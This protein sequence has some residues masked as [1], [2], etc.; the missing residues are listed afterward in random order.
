MATINV[1]DVFSSI[2]TAY[3]ID[4]NEDALFP[5]ADGWAGSTLPQVLPGGTETEVFEFG[6]NSYEVEISADQ[7]ISYETEDEVFGIAGSALSDS[8]TQNG[9]VNTLIYIWDPVES[10]DSQALIYVTQNDLPEAAV[11]AHMNGTASV[12]PLALAGDDLLYNEGY[13]GLIM[14]GM[15]GDDMI[16]GNFGSDTL[17]GGTGHDTLL[18]DEGSDRLKG[19]AGDDALLGDYG[20]DVLFGGAG[21]DELSGDEGRDRLFGGGGQD[22]LYGGGSIDV[23]KGGGGRDLLVGGDSNDRLFGGAGADTFVFNAFDGR[24][25]IKDFEIGFDTISL[26]DTAA[27]SFDDLAFRQRGDNAIVNY[28]DGRIVLVDTD[29]DELTATDFDFSFV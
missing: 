1:F 8:N 13:S 14:N 5:P 12:M 22:A 16:V 11:R 29:V 10:W 18:G 23:L 2:V 7:A 19:G 27:S 17:I 28:G 20:N 6:G 24:D 26:Q 15:A 25:K 9:L 3:E 21:S 4:I